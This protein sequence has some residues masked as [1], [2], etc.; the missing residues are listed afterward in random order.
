MI[1]DWYGVDE[2]DFTNNRPVA[3]ISR[4][5][6]T[7][8]WVLQHQRGYRPFINILQYTHNLEINSALTKIE[9]E[10]L[11]VLRKG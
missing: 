9:I 2:S 4:D 11:V 6:L 3:Q 10:Q 8:L 7:A 5:S 1:K